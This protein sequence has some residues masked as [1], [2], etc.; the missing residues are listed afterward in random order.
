VPLLL[1]AVSSLCGRGCS[2]YAIAYPHI[3]ADAV[4][5]AYPVG[6]VIALP[7]TWGA[8]VWTRR[9]QTSALASSGAA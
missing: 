7:L 8:Y 6:S 2:F 9:K 1:M 5:W 4:W 3:G